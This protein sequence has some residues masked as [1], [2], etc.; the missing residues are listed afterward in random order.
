ML[1]SFVLC[2]LFNPVARISSQ[3][4]PKHWLILHIKRAYFGERYQ[5]MFVIVMWRF[6]KLGNERSIVGL[7]LANHWARRTGNL[8]T[9]L[10]G[11]PDAEKRFDSEYIYKGNRARTGKSTELT[12]G[13]VGPP[14]GTR[15][16]SAGVITKIIAWLSKH[17]IIIKLRCICWQLVGG[18]KYEGHPPL[19]CSSKFLDQLVSRILPAGIRTFLVFQKYL[20]LNLWRHHYRFKISKVWLSGHLPWFS[21]VVSAIY[22][23]TSLTSSSL[24]GCLRVAPGVL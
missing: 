1:S 7:S 24:R 19:F 11:Q 22:E 8:T 17:E 12:Q 5:Y 9:N 16:N 2:T 13:L 10:W 4:L 6:Q 14:L 23:T 15:V 20:V 18:V 3:T 21:L